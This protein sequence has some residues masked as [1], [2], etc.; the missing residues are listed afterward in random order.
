VGGAGRALDEFGA[1]DD[2]RGGML[3]VRG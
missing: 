1:L 3:L 2:Q